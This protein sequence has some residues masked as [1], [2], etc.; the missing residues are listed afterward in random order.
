MKLVL[1]PPLRARM[2][3]EARVAFPRE[4]CGLVEGR[5]HAGVAT[6]AALHPARNIANGEDRFEIHPE[7]HFAALKIARANGRV[8]IGCYHSHPTG[9]AMPSVTDRDGAGEE[10]FLWLI[11]ALAKAD[12]PVALAAFAYSG[13]GFVSIGFAG[14]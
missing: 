12:G 3:E 1:P 5:R 6:A 11:A 7:D 8:L 2:E 10:N 4:C 14:P 13:G 9:S